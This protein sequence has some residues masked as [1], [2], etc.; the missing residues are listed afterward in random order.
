MSRIER[1]RKLLRRSFPGLYKRFGRYFHTHYKLQRQILRHARRHPA[2]YSD[3]ELRAALEKLKRSTISV[4]SF[5]GYEKYD[6][7]ALAV[8]TDGEGFPW[9]EHGGRRLYFRC[10]TGADEVVRD[11]RRLLSE[12]DPA[13]P[14]R[15]RTDSFEV[16]EG[17]L[18]MDIGAAEG[19][20]AL[21]NIEKA[22][23]VIIFEV[24][25]AWVAALK[26]TFGPWRD[27]VE[28]INRYASD[29]D[30]DGNLTVDT[31]LQDYGPDAP[32]LLK[33]DVE[34]AEERV[35][36]GAREALSRPGTRAVVCTYHRDGDHGRL[37]GAMRGM[38]FEVS[39]SSG[40]M[41]FVHGK[42]LGPPFFRRGVI[43]CRKPRDENFEQVL[44]VFL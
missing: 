43:Y 14:H 34:G 5:P 7:L 1:I 25:E 33:L 11:Y 31:A 19:I 44:K 8:H 29:T 27:K 16:M 23:R 3:P 37:S 15:Y 2:Q 38:G 40:W 17:D 28:I 4:F 20:F 9:V 18:L 42:K 24:D 21:D 26:R 35:L 39:T 10:G 6:D 41:L 32:L 30:C 13:S 36:R 22:S 12:Q